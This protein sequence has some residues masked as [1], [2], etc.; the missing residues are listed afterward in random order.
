MKKAITLFTMFVLAGAMSVCFAQQ[1]Q[2]N[3]TAPNA[4]QSSPSQPSDAQPADPSAAQPQASSFEGMIVNADS[5]YVLKTKDTTYQLDD[6][7]KAKK[8]SGQ[9]VEVNG[10]LDQSTNTIHVSDISPE[11]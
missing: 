11:S 5:M 1:D 6:Q 4:D 7:K 3:Q 9:K 8:F 2:P 10:S